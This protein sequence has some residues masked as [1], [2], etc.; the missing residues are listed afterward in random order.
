M[1]HRR[2]AHLSLAA[3]AIVL[4]AAG[5]IV[6]YMLATASDEFDVPA[7]IDPAARDISAD[8][9]KL[10]P[11]G[12][13][14]ERGVN[15]AFAG[16]APRLRDTR[17]VIVPAYLSE[18]LQLT[19]RIGLTDYFASQIDVLREE[20]FDIAIAPVDTEARV[21]DNAAVL[22]RLVAASERPVCLVSHSKGGLD[23]LEF[24]R[25]ADDTEREKVACWLALQ[26]PFY[27]SPIADFAAGSKP[28]RA[29][30]DPLA[31]LLGGSGGSLDDLTVARR[32]RYM[33]EHAAAIRDIAATLPV[34]ALATRIDTPTL[35]LPTIYMRPAY[36]WMMTHDMPNDGL[37]PVTS[38]VLPGAR[39]LVLPGIDH[40]DTVADNPVLDTAE[41][42][43]LLF[44]A[45]LALTVRFETPAA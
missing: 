20:G 18:G 7:A 34:L 26:A 3:A 2:F 35:D 31:E 13:P 4:L 38:A 17:I 10:W 28:V 42:R 24:L 15:R 5:G 23:V 8:F 25:M 37:V 40:V 9:A 45:L 19:N 39:Y 33:A 21:T 44:K 29:I 32:T 16:I 41:K 12:G 43:L 36:D 6:G 11:E 14:D 30:A 27:G 1:L 22:A